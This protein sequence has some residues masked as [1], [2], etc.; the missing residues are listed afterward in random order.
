MSDHSQLFIMVHP[1]VVTVRVFP[2][3]SAFSSTVFIFTCSA[4]A[5]QD[6]LREDIA[7]V[8]FSEFC[9]GNGEKEAERRT[10]EDIQNC[11]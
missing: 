6:H 4:H 8:S 2:R 7:H 3:A 5:A 10:E 1:G 11:L 9:T